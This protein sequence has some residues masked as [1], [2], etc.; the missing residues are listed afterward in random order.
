MYVEKQ[1][2][3]VIVR[4]R[5]NQ[6]GI[7]I[8][9]ATGEIISLTTGKLYA[10][11]QD[12]HVKRLFNNAEPLPNV[13]RDTDGNILNY[14]EPTAIV[15][16]YYHLNSD[17]RVTL[18]FFVT[19][20]QMFYN[21]QFA[22]SFRRV[23]AVAKILLDNRHFQ[24]AQF[25]NYIIENELHEFDVYRLA[26]T[27][28]TALNNIDTTDLNE[29]QKRFVRTMVEY[30]MGKEKIEYIIRKMKAEHIEFVVGLNQVMEYFT[31]CDLVEQPYNQRNFLN[32]FADMLYY[33]SIHKD[34]IAL[35]KVKL[36]QKDIFKMDNDK[37]YCIMPTTPKEFTDMGKT[38][39]NCIGGY[40]ESVADGRC[41]IVFVYSRE[42]GKAIINIHLEKCGNRGYNIRQFNTTQNNDAR[43]KYSDFYNAYGA[44][45]QTIEE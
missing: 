18:P 23:K 35:R 32:G 41:V 6:K 7:Q 26:T 20:M 5:E 15:G 42:T 31:L 17:E 8:N 22:I 43:G 24:R 11:Q 38:M 1:R 45:I 21:R 10:Y 39:Q 33:K 12:N 13:L 25:V 14:D 28:L 4:A 9:I 36:V 16:L 19:V 34:E 2:A 44:Y 30:N 29:L 27:Y 3:N 40:Y 37:Y